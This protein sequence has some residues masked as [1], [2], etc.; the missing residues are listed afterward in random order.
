MFDISVETDIDRS[1]VNS[2][3]KQAIEE[4]VRSGQVTCEGADCDSRAFD[5]RV[6]ETQTGRIEGA[7]ICRECDTRTPI[8][9]DDS[10]LQDTLDTIEDAFQDLERS[11]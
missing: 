8:R 11:L 9:V 4:R 5:V 3:I 1:G 2:L 7:A 10:A 6:W